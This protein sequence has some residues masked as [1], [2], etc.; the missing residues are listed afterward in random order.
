MPARAA[1]LTLLDAIFEKLG[2]TLAAFHERYGKQHG[3]SGLLHECVAS[4]NLEFANL[5]Y[6]HGSR[7]WL[8][9]PAKEVSIRKGGEPLHSYMNSTKSMFRCGRDL[10]V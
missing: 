6:L 7:T 9:R 2:A 3:D 4:P 1:Q 8:D 10:Q 5:D